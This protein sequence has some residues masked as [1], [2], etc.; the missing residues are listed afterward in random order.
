MVSRNPPPDAM[1]PW[2]ECVDMFGGRVRWL[3]SELVFADFTSP[4]KN[5]VEETGKAS[6]KVGAAQGV[7]ALR[8]FGVGGENPGLAQNLEVMSERGL[9]DGRAGTRSAARQ[10]PTQ[11]EPADDAQPQGI[12][13][14]VQHVLQGQLLSRWKVHRG[15]L[16]LSSL[17]ERCSKHCSNLLEQCF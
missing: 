8:P 5:R 2:T 13:E 7:D 10:R 3:P 4:P 1:I 12:G 9:R 15:I 17:S 14:G 16:S 6:V 11:G